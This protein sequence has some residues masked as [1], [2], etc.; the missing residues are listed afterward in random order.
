MRRFALALSLI[1]LSSSVEAAPCTTREMDQLAIQLAKKPAVKKH[2]EKYSKLAA[3]IAGDVCWQVGSFGR[4]VESDFESM[5]DIE[6]D[7]I[8][9][10]IAEAADTR[11]VD[12]LRLYAAVQARFGA[13]IKKV[14]LPKPR[15]KQASRGSP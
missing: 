4:M 3:E 12:A 7:G 9:V 11:H 2:F 10:D 14:P 13:P 15:P 8:P 1:L 5:L 6:A